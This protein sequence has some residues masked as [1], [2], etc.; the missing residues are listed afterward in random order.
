MKYFTL[1]TTLL[2]SFFLFSCSTDEDTDPETETGT[3]TLSSEA[4]VDHLLLEDYQCES[5]TDG[6]ENSI[7]LAW[8]NVPE[9]TASLVVTMVHYPNADDLSNLNCYLVLWGIDASVTEI[10]YGAGDDGPWFMG[11]NKDGTAISY[12]SPCSPSA[13]SHEYTITISALAETPTTLPTENSIEVDYST[14][15][16]AMA[17]VE[18]LGTTSIT[19]DSVSQ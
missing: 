19:F 11:P 12:T 14:L 15:Q 8:S 5:K 2:L 9:G 4:V 13:G 16:T 10:A 18:V 17:T 3:F 7:P 6:S 1:S